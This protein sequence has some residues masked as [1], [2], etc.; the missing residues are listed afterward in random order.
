MENDNA[1]QAPASQ[2]YLEPDLSSGEYTY[3]GPK[4]CEVGDGISWISSGF[5]LFK[6]DPVQWIVT[7]IVGFIIFF[8]IQII[9]IIGGIIG[10]LTTFIWIGGLMIGCQAIRDGKNFN[11][12]YLFAGFKTR[13]GAL[14]GLSALYAL[15]TIIIMGAAIGSLYFDMMAGST[16]PEQMMSASFWLK[17][18]IAMAV[19]IPVIM[20]VWFAPALIVLQNMTVFEAM[21]ESFA[22]CLKNFLPF[23]L[24]GVVCLVLYVIAIIPLLLGLLVLVPTLF[25]SM[26]TSY[27]GIYLTK[28]SEIVEDEALL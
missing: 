20:A 28:N 1:Y 23:L 25:G 5:A 27:E 3:T 2:V 21:K 11:I 18:L 6:A 10:M 4:T 26:Y 16:D 13:P 24:Y 19:L 14:V 12:E 15:I 8:V 17:I 22:G 9:P 7:M